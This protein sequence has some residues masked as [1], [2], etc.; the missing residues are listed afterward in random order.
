MTLVKFTP[1]RHRV[2][3]QRGMFDRLF[4]TMVAN[5]ENE[6]ANETQQRWCPNVDIVERENDFLLTAELPGIDQDS[7]NISFENDV[8]TLTGNKPAE[9]GDD[10]F[11]SERC[12][13]PFH[14]AV[15][16]NAEIDQD[17]VQADYNN[18]LLTVTLPKTKE[19]R[20]KRIAVNFK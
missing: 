15:R 7:L 18:G 11:Y 5:L 16:F 17:Q 8:L 9:A 13:G 20:Q 3:H 12:F 1:A 10:L 6:N 4:D 14:R 2:S 19:S